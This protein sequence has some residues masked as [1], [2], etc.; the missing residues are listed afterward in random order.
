MKYC[1][2]LLL[3]NRT[4]K[5]PERVRLRS[6]KP[7]ETKNTINSINEPCERGLGAATGCGQLSHLQSYGRDVDEESSPLLLKECLPPH[8][9]DAAPVYYTIFGHLKSTLSAIQFRN[10]DWLKATVVDT[11]DNL[12]KTSIKNSRKKL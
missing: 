2:L 4:D 10:K 11:W 7:D 9:P 8:S 1:D 5:A 6:E 12:D 3:A